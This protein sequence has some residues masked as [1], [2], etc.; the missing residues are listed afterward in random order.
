[1]L[2]GKRTNVLIVKD[3]VG[4]AKPSTRTL[5]KDGFVFG[6]SNVH[7]TESAGEVTTS[8]K[9][10]DPSMTK[11]AKAGP[12]RDFAKL[13]KLVIKDGATEAKANRAF[14]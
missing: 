9:A 13:N 2:L 6:K 12:V 3:D 11:T 4:L 7:N 10:H 5:P 8:W 1:V 14:R